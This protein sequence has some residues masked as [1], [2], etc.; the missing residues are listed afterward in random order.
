MPPPVPP[1]VRRQQQ[2]GTYVNPGQ[3]TRVKL[4]WNLS[5]ATSQAD[6]MQSGGATQVLQQL[7][8]R[9]G[10]RYSGRASYLRLR[11]HHTCVYGGTIIQS[12][13]R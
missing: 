9:P 10:R 6:V 5:N 8:N 1:V 11:R 12:I 4:Q 13:G 7:P 2:A 3:L